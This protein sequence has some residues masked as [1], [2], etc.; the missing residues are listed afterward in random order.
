MPRMLEARQ[1]SCGQ[2]S[3]QRGG[4]HRSIFV[5]LPPTP[6]GLGTTSPHNE[7]EVPPTWGQHPTQT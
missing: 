1:G 4:G 6:L 7:V 5:L 3:A 2:I